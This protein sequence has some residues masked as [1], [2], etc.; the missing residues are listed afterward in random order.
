MGFLCNA[1][2]MHNRPICPYS[3]CSLLHFEI[4]A[5]AERPCYPRKLVLANRGVRKDRAETRGS[6]AGPTTHPHSRIKH[7]C[8]LPMPDPHEPRASL[9]LLPLLLLSLLSETP[10]AFLP[11]A[12]P[13]RVSRPLLLIPLPALVAT[14]VNFLVAIFSRILFLV[15]LTSIRKSSRNNNT[16]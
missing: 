11:A 12:L 7:K 6:R 13:S 16:L 1:E 10:R 2:E 14:S 5:F 15:L 9:L 4:S 8:H 3:S